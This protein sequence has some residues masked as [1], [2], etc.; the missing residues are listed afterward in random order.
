MRDDEADGAEMDVLEE[1]RQI[2]HPPVCV[3]KLQS[4]CCWWDGLDGDEP[5][6]GGF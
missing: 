2:F 3:G 5:V 1:K 6:W 4:W